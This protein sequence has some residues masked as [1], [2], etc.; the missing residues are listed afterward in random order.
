MESPEVWLNRSP[1]T[2]SPQVIGHFK[3]VGRVETQNGLVPQLHMVIENQKIYLG[4]R[5]LSAT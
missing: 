4:Y 5:A 3:M 1:S 2:R